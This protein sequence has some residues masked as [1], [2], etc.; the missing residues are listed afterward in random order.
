MLED[1]SEVKEFLERE[2]KRLYDDIKIN[3]PKLLK[4]NVPERKCKLPFHCMGIDS[5]GNISAG[6]RFLVPSPEFGN[7]FKEEDV[8]NNQH[9]R[10]MRRMLLDE[11]IPIMEACKHCVENC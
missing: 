9:M 5:E 7:L 4:R 2:S 10:H 3:Y 11:S 6:C 8:W 1:D